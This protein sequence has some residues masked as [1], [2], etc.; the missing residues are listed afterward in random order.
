MQQAI[1]YKALETGEY[2]QKLGVY[3]IS[4]V[5]LGALLYPVFG[6]QQNGLSYQYRLTT[7]SIDSILLPIMYSI[8]QFIAGFT[9]LPSLFVG[10]ALPISVSSTIFS[11]GAEPVGAGYIIQL[12]EWSLGLLVSVI[13][14]VLL[15]QRL[16]IYNRKR[17]G[18]DSYG[19]ILSWFSGK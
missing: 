1:T 7:P 16:I 2:P 5:V 14:S 3:S 11:T 10:N 18:S 17:V 12:A 8:E 9:F 4:T 15:L 6:L 13:V 19:G